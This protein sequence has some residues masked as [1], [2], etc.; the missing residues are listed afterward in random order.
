MSFEIPFDAVMTA[1]IFMIGVPAIVLQTLPTELRRLIWTRWTQLLSDLALPVVAA[2]VI[3]FAGVALGKV[4]GLDPNW[5][6][7]AVLGSVFCLVVFTIYRIPRKYGNRGAVVARLRRDANR[8]VAKTGRPVEHALYDLIE[9]GKQS[10]PGR[11]K[12]FVLEALSQ[13]TGDFCKAPN[14]AGDSLG[15]LVRGVIDIALPAPQKRNAQNISSATTILQA[16]LMHYEEIGS[17]AIADSDLIAAIRALSRLGRAALGL[18]IDS[19]VPLGV[20]EA[21]GINRAPRGEIFVSQSLFEVGIEAI[22]R[23]QM[24]VAM[25]ALEKLLTLVE[26]RRPA[27]GEIVADTLGLLAHFWSSGDTGRQFARS[28]LGRIRD[29]LKDELDLALEAAARHSAQTTQFRTADLV[30]LMRREYSGA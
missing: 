15:D 10:E 4:R 22:D 1:L 19:S 6:W 13:L 2:L 17:K 29:D 9:L 3:V 18:E 26:A 23:D 25:A 5:T 12:E 16:I 14:Y 27:H 24:L 30:R 8:Q 7:T 11:E 20:V 21:L 28:R